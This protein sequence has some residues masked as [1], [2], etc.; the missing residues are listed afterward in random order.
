[1]NTLTITIGISGSGKTT[2]AKQYIEN[3]KNFIRVCPDDIRKELTGDISN[4][5][6]NNEVWKLAKKRVA[7]ALLEKNVILDA[8]NLDTSQRN[9]FIKDLPAHILKYKYFEVSP[10]IAKE[11]IKKDLENNVDR[12]KVPENVIDKMSKKYYNIRREKELEE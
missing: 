5:S 2:W 3:N 12:S 10:E 4:Q 1:M 8:T 7:D 9:N 11:R 6:R